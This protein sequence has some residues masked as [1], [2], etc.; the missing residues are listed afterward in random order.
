[1][2]S[3]SSFYV[4]N[5]SN[6]DNYYNNKIFKYG[7]TY[8]LGIQFLHKSGKWSEPIFLGDKEMDKHIT[9][10]NNNNE[11]SSQSIVGNKFVYSI[12][13]NTVN[14]LI[15]NGFIAS[16]P[17]IVYPEYNDRTCICQGVLN[18][19][20]FNIYNRSNNSCYTQPI[21]SVP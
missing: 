8:R 11:I 9:Y 18:P 2:P 14:S 5:N 1:M 16:R 15:S 21:L 19:T 6:S 3:P 20:V 7:E 13:P 17:V 4:Y 12:N 10:D